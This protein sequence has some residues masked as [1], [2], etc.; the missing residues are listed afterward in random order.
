MLHQLGRDLPDRRTGRPSVSAL[1]ARPSL[2]GVGT[3][4][5]TYRNSWSS[6]SVGTN[7]R[8]TGPVA[9]ARRVLHHQVL[10]GRPPEVRCTM[11]TYLPM[12]CRECTTLVDQ[13]DRPT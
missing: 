7:S 4:P 10:A 6:A 1:S 11:S 9:F 8:V 13:P 3:S 2:F 12:P 5:P